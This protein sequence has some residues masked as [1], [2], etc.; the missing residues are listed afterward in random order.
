MIIIKIMTINREKQINIKQENKRKDKNNKKI[1]YRK[2][3]PKEQSKKQTNKKVLKS[4]APPAPQQLPVPNTPI[5]GDPCNM[6]C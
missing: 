2:K 6:S 4:P 5:H 1:K 3:K